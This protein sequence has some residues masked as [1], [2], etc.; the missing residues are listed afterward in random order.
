SDKLTDSFGPG[1]SR[2]T[3]FN[4]PFICLRIECF[5]VMRNAT[6]FGTLR[7]NYFDI[8]KGSTEAIQSSCNRTET[9]TATLKEQPQNIDEVIN[10]FD[11]SIRAVEHAGF[12]C[13]AKLGT[14]KP[15]G[16]S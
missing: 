3:Y 15:K 1:Y 5:D 6:F 4:A 13:A 14:A 11:M 8:L 10:S 2:V 9:Y 12:A 7:T 16:A